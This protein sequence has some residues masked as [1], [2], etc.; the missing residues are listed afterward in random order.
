MKRLPL[1]MMTLVF[2]LTL[3]ACGP[4]PVVN[5]PGNENYWRSDIADHT[6][7]GII[8]GA[9]W[10]MTIAEV[11]DTGDKFDVTLY[12]EPIETC[13]FAVPTKP[14]VSFTVPNHVREYFMTTNQT[15]RFAE[16]PIFFTLA[17]TGLI[18]VRSISDTSVTIGVVIEAGNDNSVNGTFDT[19]IC[20]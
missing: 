5:S 3:V 15:G 12:G 7:S 2:G 9:E 19:L 16:P 10:T 14:S 20:P 11:I 1:W 6:P 8:G 18:D 17:V 4:D 13:V